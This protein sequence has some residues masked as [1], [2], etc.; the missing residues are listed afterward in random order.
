MAAA[1]FSDEVYSLGSK[2]QKGGFEL[3]KWTG[4]YWKELNIGAVQIS[5]Q[6]NGRVTIIQDTG[7]SLALVNGAWRPI[8]SGCTRQIV[9]STFTG[10][11]ESYKLSC[12]SKTEKPAL[13]KANFGTHEWQ[14][15]TKAHFYSIAVD[16]SGTLY[17][18]TGGK[19]YSIAQHQQQYRKVKNVP[20]NVVWV[21]AGP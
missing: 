10:T 18:V 3:R 16:N 14:R 6:G 15:F 1:P 2:L 9:Y 11:K 8:D 20:A 19:L 7:T 21:V 13:F 17:G 5:V 4:N 12:P